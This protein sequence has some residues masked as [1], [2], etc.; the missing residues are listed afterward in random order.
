VYHTARVAGLHRCID[1]PT[2]GRQISSELLRVFRIIPR[3][4]SVTITRYRTRAFPTDNYVISDAR[5]INSR[6]MTHGA[7]RL[8]NS[9]QFK[10]RNF[11]FIQDLQTIQWTYSSNLHS[12][13][14]I[15][16]DSSGA[17]FFYEIE[18]RESPRIAHSLA[19]P[20]EAYRDAFRRLTLISKR[21]IQS[22]SF[23]LLSSLFSFSFI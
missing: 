8:C 10:T 2:L 9:C 3:N 4:A 18:G 7:A 15:H 1:T 19:A 16:I 13:F 5:E 6:L 21:I 11:L 17:V 22:L 20:L 12:S 23:S 14:N